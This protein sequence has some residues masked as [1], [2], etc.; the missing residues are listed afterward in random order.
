MSEC[1]FQTLRWNYYGFEDSFSVDLG[2]YCG[3][4]SGV[5]AWM[6]FTVEKVEV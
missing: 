3:K 6:R 2:H 1:G 4:Y 5:V